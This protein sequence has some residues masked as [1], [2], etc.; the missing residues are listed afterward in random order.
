MPG[1]ED[2]SNR[3]FFS[4]QRRSLTFSFILLLTYGPIFLFHLL[5]WRLIIN[6]RKGKMMVREEVKRRENEIVRAISW[7]LSESFSFIHRFALLRTSWCSS[8]IRSPFLSLGILWHNIP[9]LSLM[10]ENEARERKGSSGWIKE[11]KRKWK[12]YER[13]RSLSFSFFLILGSAGTKR[14]PHTFSLS[15]LLSCVYTREKRRRKEVVN[16]SFPLPDGFIKKKLQSSWH[17]SAS[18]HARLLSFLFDGASAKERRPDRRHHRKINRKE[19]ANVLTRDR[20]SFAFIFSL[21]LMPTA[22]QVL[23]RKS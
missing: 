2:R 8:T 6:E 17:Y 5:I 22:G 11:E 18:A 21:I 19:K 15:F 10:P 16:V 1:L 13:S 20:R 9:F 7:V 12:Q 4:L 14:S 3:L 23:K